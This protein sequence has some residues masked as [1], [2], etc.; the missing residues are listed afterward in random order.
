MYLALAGSSPV[1]CRKNRATFSFSASSWPCTMKICVRAKG[2][3]SCFVG[4]AAVSGW[5]QA[6]TLLLAVIPGFIY[7]GTRSHLRGPMPDDRE[8]GAPVLRALA[9][10]GFLALLYVGVLGTCLADFVTHPGSPLKDDRQ[11]TAWVLIVLIFVVPIVGAFLVHVA[12]AS[13]VPERIAS[14]LYKMLRI[15]DRVGTYDPTPTAWDFA[16]H[17]MQVGSGSP[18]CWPNSPDAS[19]PRPIALSA[20]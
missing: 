10:S 11:R 18:L 7:Q 9:V 13:C 20:S 4:D 8:L 17:R 15:A 6:V 5:Q 12:S 16:S 2:S 1:S 14:R 3:V 19:T